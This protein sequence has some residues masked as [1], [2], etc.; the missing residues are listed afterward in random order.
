MSSPWHAR[1]LEKHLL[2]LFILLMPASSTFTAMRDKLCGVIQ[3]KNI[4]IECERG[5][6]SGKRE[7]E[8]SNLW[9]EIYS[10]AWQAST[11]EKSFRACR[12]SAFQATCHRVCVSKRVYMWQYL[13][14]SNKSAVGVLDTSPIYQHS[15]IIS[16]HLL[17]H[18]GTQNQSYS[19]FNISYQLQFASLHVYWVKQTVSKDWTW[20]YNC[21]KYKPG[22]TH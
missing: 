20:S 22:I 12:Q 13:I 19:K 21:L 7:M 3:V 16:L 5:E 18:L 11:G 9:M 15:A 14:S 17:I 1:H 6:K 2:V 8:S 10:A 4:T